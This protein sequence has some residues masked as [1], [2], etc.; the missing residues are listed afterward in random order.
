V[1]PELKGD[2]EGGGSGEGSFIG[3]GNGRVVQRRGWE[4]GITSTKGV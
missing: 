1:V 2:V 4:R 3:E